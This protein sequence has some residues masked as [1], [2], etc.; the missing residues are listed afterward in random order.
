MINTDFSMV[1]H[2]VKANLAIEITYFNF[3][4]SGTVSLLWNIEK[5]RFKSK[6]SFPSNWVA[7]FRNYFWP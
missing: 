6:A 2:K 3:Y 1:L 5:Q 4:N 7:I